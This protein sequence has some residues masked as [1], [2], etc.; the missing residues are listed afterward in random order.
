M[1]TGAGPASI[2]CRLQKAK[3][4]TIGSYWHLNLNCSKRHQLLAAGLKQLPPYHV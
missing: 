2:F 4:V 1:N 3:P